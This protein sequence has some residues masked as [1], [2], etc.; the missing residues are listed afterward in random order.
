M[1]SVAH[2]I[3]PRRSCGGHSG[4]GTGAHERGAI[5]ADDGLGPPEGQHAGVEEGQA[6]DTGPGSAAREAGRTLPDDLSIMGFD[7]VNFSHYTF[8]KL[9][10]IDYPVGGMGEMA[11]QLILKRVY[12]QKVD[13]IQTVFEPRLVERDSIKNV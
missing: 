6:V 5:D 2:G 8:P 3:E 1:D 13:A 12:Q 10:T 11:A 7:N 4:H 9:T